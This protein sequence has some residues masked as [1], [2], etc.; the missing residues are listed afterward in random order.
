MGIPGGWW[1]DPYVTIGA[2]C[3]KNL[4]EPDASSLMT[5]IKQAFG[6]ANEIVG[7]VSDIVQSGADTA[8]AV[9]EVYAN[10]KAAKVGI[11]P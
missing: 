8:N 5:E 11:P 1:S 3:Y 2:R 10:Y 6:D 7:H 9:I 4:G